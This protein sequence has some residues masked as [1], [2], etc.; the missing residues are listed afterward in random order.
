VPPLAGRRESRQVRPTGTTIT[1][2]ER[3]IG[4]VGEQ[5]PDEGTVAVPGSMDESGGAV[6]IPGVH[7]GPALQEH[8]HHGKVAMLDGVEPPTSLALTSGACARMERTSDTSPRAAATRS[9]VW[10]PLPR[11]PI[12]R[13]SST[14]ARA[15]VRS[16]EDRPAMAAW[17]SLQRF[18]DCWP[19][20]MAASQRD[21]P[22]N[23]PKARA[24][25]IRSPS[26]S[27]VAGRLLTS[28]RR[29]TRYSEGAAGTTVSSPEAARR[30]P[31]LT[32]ALYQ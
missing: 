10:P 31:A 7:V 23:N 20:W 6:E 2:R 3:Q 32:D 17:C 25:G 18:H 4:P 26:C 11:K 9:G 12:S 29:S 21:I 19:H 28:L 14:T 8:R 22:T 16:Q 15:A 5:E 24:A 13:P 30:T 1:V 27:G